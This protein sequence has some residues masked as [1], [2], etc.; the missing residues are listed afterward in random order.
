MRIGAIEAGGT[1]F[2]CGIGNEQGHME[3]WCSFPTEHP[4]ITLAKVSDY[5]RDKGVVA[6]GIG[7]FG[8]IDLKPDSLTYGYITTTPKSEWENCNV[9][10]ILKREFPV[11]FRWDTDVNA[12]ALGEVTWGAA[13]GL[14]NCVYYT[15]GTGVG[16]GI[17]AGGK[18]IH[19]LL[20]PEGGHIRTRRHPQDHF[21]GLCKYHGDCLEGLAAGPAIEARWQTPGSELPTDHLVWEIESF[22][23]AESVTTS[24]LLHSPQKIILGGGVMQQMHLFPM[25]REQVVHNLHGY[26]NVPE[27]LQHIDQYIIPPGLGQHAGLYGALALGI[28]ALNQV[29]TDSAVSL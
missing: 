24:I 15:I 17:I 22:Y 5:F 10:G 6:I 14:D 2:V 13:Q 18:R 12:A 25:I 20:H 9:V 27:L 7:S 11:P 1:K 16:V 19:G 4:E 8:P 23:I 28:E 29:R 21:A 3:E 26:V